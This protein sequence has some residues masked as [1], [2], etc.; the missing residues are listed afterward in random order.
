LASGPAIVTRQ[1]VWVIVLS[2]IV[3]GIFMPAA[4]DGWQAHGTFGMRIARAE[5]LVR[6]VVP[7]SP[8]ALAGIAPGDR[9][10]IAALGIARHL[11]LMAPHAG[12]TLDLQID[13]AGAVR[14]VTLTA[15]AEDQPELLRWLIAGEFV[16]TAAFV[17]VGA[18]LVF[19][20]PAPMTWWLWL[21]CVGIVPVNE[22]L[23][24]YAFLPTPVQTATWLFA[25]IFLGGFSVFPLMP[26]VLRFPNDRISGW[27]TGMRVPAIALTAVLLAF[28]VTI[29]WVGLTRG[30][31]HYSRFNGLPA[32]GVYAFSA[33]LLLLTY[34]RSLGA[35]RQRLKWAV[36]GMIAGFVAQIFVYV[37]AGPWLAP[38]AGIISIVM[39]ISVAYG[40]LR[41]RL[42]DAD[43]VI[44]RAIVYGL[45]TAVLISIV[46]LVDFL[47]S[48]FIGEYHLA[49]YLEAAASIAIGFA[50]DRFR[51]QLDRL[52][53]RL[54]F[55]ARHRAEAQMDRLARSL[56]FVHEEHT[57]RETLIVEPARWL[58]L[59]SAALFEYDATRTVYVRTAAMGWSDDALR[60]IDRDALVVRFLR[61]ERAPLSADDV[62]SEA[63]ALP[64]GPASPA[65]YVPVFRREQLYG[66]L[67]YG[68]HTNTTTLDPGEVAML[69]RFG[70]RAALAFEHLAYDAMEQRYNAAFPHGS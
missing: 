43:F 20:R 35:E 47:V 37:P 25:R 36:S 50:L 17:I 60:E 1:R 54:F 61:E 29:A 65:L 27:R 33:V 42:I 67:V 26:F 70:P 66:I 30:L 15:I 58:G 31:D 44:N 7:G 4:T 6:D 64:A 22:L 28:Y 57:I 11:D 12:D 69:A 9:V 38:L 56:E 59:A 48:Q 51:S 14:A 3:L 32:L 63:P 39:P 18:L 5:N 21:F 49:L 52:T 46:S 13:H 40:A 62:A 2:L 68:A 53:D 10:D 8:A 23:D 19:L 24:F 16:S 34:R 45:L 41:H 55:Q